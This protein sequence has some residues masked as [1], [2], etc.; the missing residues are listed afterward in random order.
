M[1]AESHVRLLGAVGG[2]EKLRLRRVGFNRHREVRSNGIAE[3][4]EVGTR[5]RALPWALM[6]VTPAPPWLAGGGRT[7]PEG[8]G[9]PR[10]PPGHP[11]AT[12]DS[13]ERVGGAGLAPGGGGGSVL[14]LLGA[15]GAVG[16]PVH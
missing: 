15:P 2:D 1:G 3:W 14:G 16:L 4:A 7:P 10:E 8:G 13:A 11:Q 6:R 9:A 12:A 5:Q